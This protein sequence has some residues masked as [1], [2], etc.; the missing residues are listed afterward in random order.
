M[1]LKLAVLALLVTSAFAAEPAKINLAIAGT[2]EELTALERI[3]VD[4]FFGT[5][6]QKLAIVPMFDTDFHGIGEGPTGPSRSDYA[7]ST[8]NLKG[9][10]FPVFPAGTF[11][12]SDVHIVTLQPGCVVIT[13]IASGPGP[14]GKPWSAFLSSTWVKRGKEWKTVYYQETAIPAPKS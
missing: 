5:P 6:E 10:I 12:M 14:D 7:Q 9:P 3:K 2:A 4:Y 11:K 1:K 8:S 13:Y